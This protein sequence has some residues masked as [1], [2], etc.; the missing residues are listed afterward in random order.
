MKQEIKDNI[1]RL[2]TGDLPKEEENKLYEQMDRDPSLKELF[3]SLQALYQSTENDEEP[4]NPRNATKQYDDVQLL[5]KLRQ[6]SKSYKTNSTE[7]E[8]FRLPNQWTATLKIKVGEEITDKTLHAGTTL[9]GATIP[10]RIRIDDPL[11]S[12]VH[13]RFLFSSNSGSLWI[14][15]LESTNGTFILTNGTRQQIPQPFEVLGRDYYLTS[16]TELYDGAQISLGDSII[17]VTIAKSNT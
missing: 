16:P 17:S 1:L 9:I 14:E 2:L 10:C 13:A 12:S 8:K 15:D 7:Q 4:Y 11:I 6:F 5:S 3:V